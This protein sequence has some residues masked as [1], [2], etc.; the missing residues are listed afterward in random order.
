MDDPVSETPLIRPGQTN[1]EHLNEW[2]TEVQ[3]GQVAEDKAA[4]V[5]KAD[6]HD[7]SQIHATCHFNMLSPIKQP[8]GSCQ[9]L[10]SDRGKDHVP[11]CQKYSCITT[12][13][14]HRRAYAGESGLG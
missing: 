2:Y 12:E 7:D 11:A 14:S 1:L 3:I 13:I 8:C 5:K 4:A 6:W 10:R 9:D